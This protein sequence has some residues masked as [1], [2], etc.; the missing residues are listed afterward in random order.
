MKDRKGKARGAFLK[1]SGVVV[2]ITALGF[3]LIFAAPV[4]AQSKDPI[5]IGFI[6]G[7]TGP[8]GTEAREQEAAGIMAVEEANARGGVLGRKVEFL[9]RD[10]KLKIDEAAKR[11]KELLEKDKVNFLM[12]GLINQLVLNEQCKLAKTIFFACTKSNE[13]TQAP[14]VSPYTFA[15]AANPYIL[16]RA[17]GPWIFKNLGKKW[18]MLAADYPWGWQLNEGFQK[19]GQELGYTD[20][21]MI[22]HPLGATDYTA[23]FPKIL[24]A[25]PDVLMLNNFGKDQL[26]SVK[27]AFEFG[28]KK[29][30][31]IICPVPLITARFGA[32]DDAF[33][34]VYGGTTFYWELEKTIPSARTFV[35]SYQKRWGKPPIDYAAYSYS[36]VRNILG[37]VERAGSLDVKKCIQQLEGYKYDNYKGQQWFRPWDHRSMQDVFIIKSKPAKDRKGEWDVFQILE[38]VKADDRLERSAEQLGLKSGVALSSSL[39]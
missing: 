27:Q 23:Y 6:I 28:L 4:G 15:E 35:T 19:V 12:G 11:A 13:I 26:N 14:D 24:A 20:C 1:L 30:M 22:K 39:K 5:K 33:E 9:V 7:L 2:L 34:D 25:G 16:T 8:Y 10:D 38:T 17:V 37:A 32:G 29:K 18:F 21:G 36:A 3:G 31:K